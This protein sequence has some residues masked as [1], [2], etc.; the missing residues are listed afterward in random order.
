[1]V[2]WCFGVILIWCNSVLLFPTCNNWC[3]L[4]FSR[5]LEITRGCYLPYSYVMKT[6]LESLTA[7]R[8]SSDL[9]QHS[10]PTNVTSSAE[11]DRKSVV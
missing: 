11:S 7:T 3:F 9:I 6:L 10:T 5:N 4:S 8:R 1:M 2:I